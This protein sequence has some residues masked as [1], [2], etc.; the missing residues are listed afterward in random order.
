[1]PINFN[2]RGKS[3]FKTVIGF[4]WTSILVISVLA[5][6]I[7]YFSLFYYKSGV[8][9]TSREDTQPI[10]PKIDLKDEQLFFSVYAVK[11]GKPIGLD[12]LKDHFWFE[13]INYTY[14]YE[15]EVGG[16]PVITSTAVKLTPCLAG[17][18]RPLVKNKPISGKTGW[19][20][21]DNAYCSQFDKSERMVLEGNDNSLVFSFIEITVNPC[22]TTSKACF[23]YYTDVSA[24]DVT[25]ID[26]YIADNPNLPA[27]AKAKFDN[28][29][30]PPDKRVGNFNE[31]LQGT[32]SD[33]LKDIT[34]T[35]SYIEGAIDSDEY[36]D[37]YNLIMK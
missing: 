1:M 35:F 7:F 9:V 6:F 20:I 2:I 21:S 32:L 36:N 3:S 4:A 25:R 12:S 5:V 22:K 8:N 30:T 16:A 24:T 33:K 17:G 14:T 10:F 28:T 15:Q 23:F 11:E 18:R 13:S 37:P 26:E 19:A 27:N 34:V 31:Y 29:V